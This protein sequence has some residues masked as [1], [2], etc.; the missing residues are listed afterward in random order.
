M[1]SVKELLTNAHDPILDK[2]VNLLADTDAGLQMEQHK[3]NATILAYRVTIKDLR[4]KTEQ[5]EEYLQLVKKAREYK[6]HEDD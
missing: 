1:G 3:C 4:K 6:Q 2:E 5:A